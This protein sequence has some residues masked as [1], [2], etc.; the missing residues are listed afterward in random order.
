[1]MNGEPSYPFTCE[2]QRHLGL[3]QAF[4][5]FAQQIVCLYE[6]KFSFYLRNYLDPFTVKLSS[7]QRCLPTTLQVFKEARSIYLYSERRGNYRLWDFSSFFS[8]KEAYD[9]IMKTLGVTIAYPRATT[10]D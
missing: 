8:I 2:L 9:A 3:G 7:L 6:D 4:T 1:M 5:S 10:R